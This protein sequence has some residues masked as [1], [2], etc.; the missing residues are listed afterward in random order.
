MP[1]P[2]PIPL[3]LPLLLPK[4]SDVVT[5][6]V[7]VVVVVVVGGVEM[8][9]TRVESPKRVI[10]PR[11]SPMAMYRLEDSMI[12]QIVAICW[13]AVLRPCVL[14]TTP[15]PTP[16][17]L[18]LAL[19]PVFVAVASAIA[20]VAIAVAVG[21]GVGVV[22]CCPSREYSHTLTTPLI[23]A[24]INLQVPS[25]VPRWNHTLRQ[26]SCLGGGRLMPHLQ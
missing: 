4:A 2:L 13:L 24:V 16:L 11:E 9:G 3:P 6:V 7:V 15:T 5:Q 8:T 25:K 10:P 22:A 17:A 20:P 19:A 23:E 21:V 14:V 18:A 12:A 1:I 26:R